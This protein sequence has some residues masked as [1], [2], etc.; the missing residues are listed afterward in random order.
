M[1]ATAIVR[2]NSI[3]STNLRPASGVP[4]TDE[5]VLAELGVDFPL[6]AKL[7]EHRSLSKLKGTYTDA[8]QTHI[9]RETG[10]VH[11]SFSLAAT[12]TV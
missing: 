11:T 6:P 7:L 2:T 8:L 4:S 9:N 5:D 3:V 10:R 12:T 1:R